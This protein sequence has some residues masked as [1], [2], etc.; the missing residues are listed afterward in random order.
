[1]TAS[2][3]EVNGGGITALKDGV[4]QPDKKAVII[5]PKTAARTS[6]RIGDCPMITI[7][8]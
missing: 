6:A 3:I 8:V 1:M 7:V 4:L 2:W 5:E